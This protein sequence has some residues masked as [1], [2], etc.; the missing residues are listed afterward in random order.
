MDQE[1]ILIVNWKIISLER[2]IL[3]VNFMHFIVEVIFTNIMEHY[4]FTVNIILYF[5]N[6]GMCS[7]PIQRDM[8]N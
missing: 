7:L 6:C 1:I 2:I 5:I 4:Y 8:D 3:I